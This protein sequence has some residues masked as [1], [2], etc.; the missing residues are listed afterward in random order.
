MMKTV[1]TDKCDEWAKPV[2]GAVGLWWGQ[3]GLNPGSTDFSHW[4]NQASGAS[5]S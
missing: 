5:V 2:P 3:P 1:D 4:Y